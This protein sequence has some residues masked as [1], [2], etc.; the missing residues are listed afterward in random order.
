MYNNILVGV[1][2]SE[3]SDKALKVAA[4]LA[5]KFGAELHVFHSVPHHY[6]IP[7]NP[8]APYYAN[9]IRESSREILE[10]RK[11]FEM[12]GKEILTQARK[13]LEEND[14]F[15]E[16]KTEF[17]LELDASPVEFSS[18]FAS[19]NGVDLIVIGCKGHH[20]RV[21]RVLMGTVATGIANEAPCPV[22]VVR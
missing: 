1:D 9:P 17:H 21:R 3:T 15:I 16:D 2:S 22:L 19:E 20:S 5:K 8:V 6:S 10:L 7:I 18:Q 11:A 4:E 13:F 14:L 12:A